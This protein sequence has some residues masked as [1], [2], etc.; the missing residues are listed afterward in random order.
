MRGELTGTGVTESSTRI[1]EDE[2]I[3]LVDLAVQHRE[4]ASEVRQGWDDVIARS[5]Y[6]LG[7]EV[8]R[9]EDAFAAFAGLR[10]CV[11]VASGTD[12][13]EL[14]LRACDIGPGDDVIVPANTFIAT[15]LAVMRAGARPVVVDVD[16]D[17][18]L[19]DLEQMRRHL[20]RKLKAVVPVHLYG[21]LV[22]MEQLRAAL[23]GHDVMVVEDAAQAHGARR[24]GLHAGA[25]GAAAA[26]SF[27]PG[28]NLGAYGDA[29]AVLTDSPELAARIRALRNWGGETKYEHPL[30]GFNSRLDTIQAVVLHAKLARLAA[31]NAA[32]AEAAAR[33]RELL[34]DVPDVVAPTVVA[35]NEHVWHLYV[36]RVPRR[37]AVLEALH[38]RGIGAGIHYP[39]PIHLQG[40]LASLGHGPGDFPVAEAA[41]RTI[42]SLPLFPGITELQQ[43]R[44]VDALR[45]ALMR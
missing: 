23:D 35:G 16:A 1:V 26:T 28:K 36:V 2:P 24:H 11:G 19:L 37:D 22:P 29:G 31:W 27:Y 12:A 3:P 34:A 38:E 39:V 41:A 43:V 10:A 4:V 7:D 45:D 8:R 14:A 32:R 15:A 30:A 18:Y 6:V 21:Q 5:A 44:V 42:L 9:F 20:G 13:I 17:S 40:A 25:L 33:Y